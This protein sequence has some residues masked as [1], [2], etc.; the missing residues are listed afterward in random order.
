MRSS[1]DD[2]VQPGL[3]ADVRARLLDC[4]LGRC[5]HV[6]DIQILDRYEA[7]AAY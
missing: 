4:A 6:P 2:A 7:E 1:Q 5:R 3:L